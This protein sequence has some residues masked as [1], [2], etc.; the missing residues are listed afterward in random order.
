[1][2]TDNKEFYDLLDQIVN[3]QTFDLELTNGQT[4]KC[5]QL[6]TAQLK[7]LIKTVV[8]S[9]LTQAAFNSTATKIFKQSIISEC[10]SSS[11][12][13]VD[14]LL[15]ILEARIQSISPVMQAEEEGKTI[16]IDFNQV[17]TNLL[18]K[19]KENA[20]LFAP[21][22]AT[23]GK[24]TTNIEVPLLNTESLLNDEI[25]RNLVVDVNDAEQLR[26]VLGEAFINE[27]AKSIKSITID[28]KTLD[29]ST[30]T[31]KSRLKT[32]E[33]LPALLVQKVIEYIEKYK[34]I[35]DNCMTVEGYTIPV[36][37][38]LFSLR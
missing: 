31:F 20:N 26:K 24:I 6:S 23:D 21:L 28:D 37:S 17:K 38:S 22:E 25:Y 13:T 14:R 7:E 8:D 4:V 36:D 11:L 15:F 19:L 5:K 2:S 34:K 30:V 35:I 9:P 1:M 10:D 29:F 33:S 32:I 27:I 16:S 18:A 12:T 3:E